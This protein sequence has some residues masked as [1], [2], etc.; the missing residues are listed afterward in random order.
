[1]RSQ[2]VWSP[3]IRAGSAGHRACAPERAAGAALARQAVADE[4]ADRLAVD[5]D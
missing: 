5:L 1:M 3:L 2:S 4:D